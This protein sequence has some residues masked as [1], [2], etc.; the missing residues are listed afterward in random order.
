MS[1]NTVLQL[2]AAVITI[3]VLAVLHQGL[4]WFLDQMTPQFIYGAAVGAGFVMI[5]WVMALWMD[6][7]ATFGRRE[8]K[9]PR[10]TIDL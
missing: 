3:A 9:S 10:D 6:R 4:G 2:I 8:Q 1:M 7:S 5:M